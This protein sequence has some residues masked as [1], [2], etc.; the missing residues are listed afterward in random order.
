MPSINGNTGKL[1]PQ[2]SQ[3]AIRQEVLDRLLTRIGTRPHRP[4]YGTL[5]RHNSADQQSTIDS[6]NDALS[7]YPA[8]AEIDIQ[9][10]ADSL[11]IGLLHE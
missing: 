9:K 5:L 8:I 4:T 11:R 2:G 7:D 10:V 1:Y 6:V 3:D